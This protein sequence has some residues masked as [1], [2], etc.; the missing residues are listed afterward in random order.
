MNRYLAIALIMGWSLLPIWG[1]KRGKA[2]PKKASEPVKTETE[3][4]YERMLGSTAKVMFIDSVVVDLSEFIQHIPLP[5]ASGK[6]GK[7][8]DLL[9]DIRFDG[10]AFLNEFGNTAIYSS[11]ANNHFSLYTTNRVA[12]VWEKGK[13]LDE[14]ESDESEANYP[15]LMADG[16]TLF[17]TAKGENSV[18]GYDIMMT[19]FDPAEGKYFAPQNYGLPFNSP[20]DDY[21]LA[22]D[23]P[24]NLG[25]LVTSRHQPEGKVCIYSFEPIKVRVGFEAD[26]LSRQQLENYASIHRIADTWKFGN[27]KAALQR[28]EKLHNKLRQQKTIQMVFVINDDITYHSAT[29]FQNPAARQLL[30]QLQTMQQEVLRNEKELELLRENYQPDITAGKEKILELEQKCQQLRLLIAQVE[31]KIRNMEINVLK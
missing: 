15:F 17:F 16:I 18:G 10:Y 31:K 11:N 21:L 6:I 23:E 22:I 5:E 25:W 8:T 3:K 13:K 1:Q 9:P 30:P 28:L 29:D 24:D 20:A 4:R 2:I 27:R 26:S 7:T 12:G 19:R 14:I